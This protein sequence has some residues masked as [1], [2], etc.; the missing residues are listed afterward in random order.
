MIKETIYSTTVE[1]EASVSLETN[2]IPDAYHYYSKNN[3]LYSPLTNRPVENSI[4]KNSRLDLVE[5]EA[6]E[7]IQKWFAK[8]DEG[9]VIWISPPHPERSVDTKIVFS[10]IVYDTGFE[11]K[12]RNRAIR[13]GFS[14]KD[15]F[16]FAKRFGFPGI[17][18]GEELAASPLFPDR[19][20]A[21]EFVDILEQ[22]SR[23]QAQII[24]GGKDFTIKETLK[25]RIA[26]GYAAPIGPY[27]PSCPPT[28]HSAFEQMFGNSFNIREHFDCPR[29]HRQIPSGRGITT[30]PH[31]GARKEDYHRCD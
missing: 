27:S 14:L 9:V 12:L 22:Y 28:M 3:L 10:D 7:K 4:S 23:K 11:K 6:F 13:L 24:K 21:D 2:R 18:S 5:A 31:C 15:C 19:L 17:V 29:C 25:A 8:K 20:S 30:C 26:L 1:Y 16:A